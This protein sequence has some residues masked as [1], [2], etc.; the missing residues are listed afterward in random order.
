MAES[1]P[2]LIAGYYGFGNLGDEAILVALEGELHRANLNYVTLSPKRVSQDTF[3][4]RNP[5][6]LIAAMQSC[7]G[8]VF[9]GGGLLQT[10]TSQHSLYYYLA[11]IFLAR[12]LRLPVYVLGQGVGPIDS[13]L[14][15]KLLR[16]ALLKSDYISCRDQSSTS[17]LSSLGV[18]AIEGTDLFFLLP[19]LPE[20]Q[21][22][23]DKIPTVLL[24][25]KKPTSGDTVPFVNEVS[26]LIEE[27]KQNLDAKIRLL[28]FFLNEDLEIAEQIAK[29]SSA[30]VVSTTSVDQAQDL[31]EQADL[32]ISSRLHPL[33][34]ALR[35]GTPMW[36]IP[37][38]P[39][40]AGFV[41][42]LLN[43]SVRIPCS[44]FPNSQDVSRFLQ[45]DSESSTFK[46]AYEDLHD[47]ATKQFYSFISNIR[48]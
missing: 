10:K 3:S 41:D 34:F 20:P 17:L 26:T 38:V 2:L 11:L 33:E 13:R 18:R 14:D 9:G 39:K 48:S 22:S 6:Q 32:V 47:R 42:T 31:I 15:R 36:A 24:A 8:I 19:P 12:V 21:R 29:R 44:S 46:A 37:E 7:S 35:A 4:R 27:L 23:T 45:D 1:Q 30:T 28:P 40:I 16:I 25:L 5:F 43:H